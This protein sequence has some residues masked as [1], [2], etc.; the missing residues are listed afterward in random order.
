M[1]VATPLQM[2]EIDRKAITE[3]GI[4]GIVL[5]E[6]AALQVVREIERM[7]GE[8]AGKKILVFAG[9]GNN[10]GDAFAVARHLYNKG[11]RIGLCVLACRNSIKGDA[12]VNLAIIEKMGIE[13][14]EIIGTGNND[15]NESKDSNDNKKDA[16]NGD[17]RGNTGNCPGKDSMREDTENKTKYLKGIQY[18]KNWL[19]MADLVVDGIFGTG[20]KGEITGV[21]AEIIKL[22]NSYS[23]PV[24]SIDI[25]SGI[26]GE[27]GDVCGVCIKA[28]KTV[29]FGLPKIGLILF[30]GCE[31]A[32]ELIVADIGIPPEVLGGMGIKI[33]IIEKKTVAS[34]IPARERQTNKGDYGKVLIIS[35]SRGMTGAGCLAARAAH[36]AGAGLVYLAVP[37]SLLPVYGASLTETIVIPVEDQGKGHIVLDGVVFLEKQM[38]GKDVIAAGPGLSVN[39]GT[40]GF[41]SRIIESSTLPLVLDADAL[42]AI[43]HDVSVLKRLKTTAVITPHPGEMARLTGKST[44]QVQRDRVNMAREF[45]SKWGVITVLKG[46]RTVVALPDETIYINL[47]GNPGMATA[48]TGDVLTGIIAGLIAQGIKPEDAAVAGVYLHGLAGDIAAFKKGEYGLVAS[49]LV[50]E[51]PGAIMEIV[52]NRNRPLSCLFFVE[53]N[54]CGL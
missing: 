28:S 25:P 40:I 34:M 48:G 17:N 38:E 18:A 4:P 44:D 20:L 10:G 49:N 16:G 1:Q 7:L 14:V 9:K 6:N 22:I 31:Y 33:H 26:N 41:I 39:E 46:F 50:D 8:V 45:A 24:I 23:K 29:T 2:R 32:G 54:G 35:G 3:Y 13:M 51:I 30:P 11:A 53:V 43:A 36:R 52:D 27:T 37:G 47:T 12:A 5:M 42:N 15:N 21:G 19:A